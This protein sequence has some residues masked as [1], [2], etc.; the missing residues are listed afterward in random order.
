MNGV[1]ALCP[2]GSSGE[3]EKRRFKVKIP[4]MITKPIIFVVTL[5]DSVNTWLLLVSLGLL[6]YEKVKLQSR[7]HTSGENIEGPL[8]VIVVTQNSMND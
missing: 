5:T 4:K 8:N 7:L 3:T 2:D 1:T 6:F